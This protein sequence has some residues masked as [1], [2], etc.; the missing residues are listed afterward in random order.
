LKG[1]VGVGEEKEYTAYFFLISLLGPFVNL[2]S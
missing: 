2:G 1:S